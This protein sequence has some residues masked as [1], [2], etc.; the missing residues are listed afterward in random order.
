[1]LTV[2]EKTINSSKVY[3]ARINSVILRYNQGNYRYLSDLLS[4][5]KLDLSDGGEQILIQ[6]QKARE[7]K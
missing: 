6:S 2:T 5:L 1:M 4:S 3:D 7:N